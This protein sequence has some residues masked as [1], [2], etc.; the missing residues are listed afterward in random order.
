ME[1]MEELVN[2][3]VV[4]LLLCKTSDDLWSLTS[5]SNCSPKKN[6]IADPIR[7]PLEIANPNE[8]P[9]QVRNDE[10][11]SQKVCSEYLRYKTLLI[12]KYMLQYNDWQ[13]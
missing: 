3:Y 2:K 7:N 4:S 13:I 9:H 8:I 12:T 10:I 5:Q 1:K 6:V 11:P